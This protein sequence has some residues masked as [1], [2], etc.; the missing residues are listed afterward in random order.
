MKVHRFFINF[1]EASV[2]KIHDKE[3]INQIKNVLKLKPSE[4]VVLIKNNCEFLFEIEIV[5]KEFI[6]LK[7][8]SKELKETKTRKTILY[9]SIIKK[10]NFEMLCQKTTECGIFKIVPIITERTV[11]KDIN[12]QRVEKILKEASEQS[13]RMDIPILSKPISFEQAI[14][15]ASQNDL[16]LFFDFN[17]KQDFEIKNNI[18]SIG[19]FIGPEGGFTEKENQLANSFEKIQLKNNTLRAETAAIIATYL[20]S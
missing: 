9:C 8:I 10:D 16:N 1:Q 4:R 7:L 2:V 12:M 13:G 14:K 15:E 17:G 3:Y 6:Q 19:L 11:K 20:Y 5:S 18:N